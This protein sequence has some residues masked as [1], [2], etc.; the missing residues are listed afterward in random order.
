MEP[1]VADHAPRGNVGLDMAAVRSTVAL[2][3]LEVVRERFPGA[4]LVESEQK[5]DQRGATH[6][7]VPIITE[8]KEMRTDDPVGGLILPHNSV[9]VTLRLMQLPPRAVAGEVIFSN[10]ARLT[11]NQRAYRLLDNR[12]REV[13]T[14]LI[15]GAPA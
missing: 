3:I 9:S 12:F 7:L 11:L 8:W 5:A 6:L 4:E 15:A 1:L 2:R 10:H 13:L 14:R